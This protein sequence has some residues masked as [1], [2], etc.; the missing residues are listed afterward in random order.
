MTGFQGFDPAAIDFYRGL[1]ADNS[2][3]Y[4]QAHRSTYEEGIRRPLE[5]LL[6]E[7][8]DEFGDAKVFRPNRDVRFSNDKS[9]YKSHQGAYVATAPACGW[10]LEVSADGMM[11]GGGFYHASP[12]GLANLRERIDEQGDELA[13]IVAGL[14]EDGWTLGGETL[15]TAPRGWSVDH[16]RIELLRHKSLSLSRPVE[17]AVMCSPTLVERVRDDWEQLRELLEW[18]RPAL[19]GTGEERRR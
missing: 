10:Y 11:T 8:T 18:L 5:L 4:W 12:E 9:P 19:E 3:Q 6:A 15:R 13:A 1:E 16:P 17:D 2:R 14:V 7:L